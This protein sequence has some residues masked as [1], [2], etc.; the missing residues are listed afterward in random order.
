MYLQVYELNTRL[1]MST[2]E[3]KTGL[4]IV[5]HRDKDPGSDRLKFYKHLQ[6]GV[7]GKE[8]KTKSRMCE[9]LKYKGLHEEEKALREWVPPRYPVTGQDIMDTYVKKG[10]TLG[11][12]LD[13][14]RKRWVKSD[15][16]L[17]KEEL[18][19]QIGEILESKKS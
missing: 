17:T 2:D 5:H 9:L 1:K 13:E 3:L 15:F 4:F 6:V 16:K 10:P 14:L 18:L 12:V 11:I 8:P 19:S 7:S